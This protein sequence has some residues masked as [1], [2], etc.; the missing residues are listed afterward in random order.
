ML[1]LTVPVLAG[2]F[3]SDPPL[4]RI[5]L[6]AR[7]LGRPP[8]KSCGSLEGVAS[9]GVDAELVSRARTGIADVQTK[10]DALLVLSVDT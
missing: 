9:V 6:G 5:A 10:G 4:A 2:L 1:G 3:R 7:A 8:T